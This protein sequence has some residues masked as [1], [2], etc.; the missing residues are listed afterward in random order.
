MSGN[1]GESGCLV[2]VDQTGVISMEG[3]FGEVQRGMC[4]CTSSQ[5]N[6]KL[7]VK[8]DSVFWVSISLAM[9]LA[10]ACSTAAR[11]SSSEL[12]ACCCMGFIALEKSEEGSRTEEYLEQVQA[13]EE[14]QLKQ[15]SGVTLEP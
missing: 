9:E 12:G 14:L 1:A 6:W 15:L 4:V 7:L 11:W 2:G 13:R 5:S 8:S 10:R 3:I